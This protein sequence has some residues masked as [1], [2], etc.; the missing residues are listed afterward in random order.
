MCRTRPPRI[1]HFHTRHVNKLP[2]LLNQDSSNLDRKKKKKEKKQHTTTSH[3]LAEINTPPNNP[4]RPVPSCEIGVYIRLVRRLHTIPRYP[5]RTRVATRARP[6]P[7]CRIIPVTAPSLLGRFLSNPR[8]LHTVAN[9]NLASS[10]ILASFLGPLFVAQ[11]N[12]RPT[13]PQTAFLS[14]S[15]NSF[16]P[17]CTNHHSRLFIERTC[18]EQCSSPGRGICFFHSR[19]LSSGDRF[20][21]A[22]AALGG[23]KIL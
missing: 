4:N 18:R 23:A 17:R 10:L 19:G 1:F 11:G 16:Y 8:H 21:P 15:R 6:Q 5:L 22:S 9:R 13:H 2:P 7:S 3:S 20:G 14:G 12:H